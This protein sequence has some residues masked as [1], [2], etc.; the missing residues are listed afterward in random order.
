MT[1]T[2]HK[3][4]RRLGRYLW[5]RI[6]ATDNHDHAALKAL[7]GITFDLMD[8]FGGKYIGFMHDLNMWVGLKRDAPEEFAD[9]GEGIRTDFP[10][11]F[12]GDDVEE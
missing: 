10:E 8:E 6:N 4:H 1:T 2:L 3:E 12:K 11:F 5:E 7:G 9:Y